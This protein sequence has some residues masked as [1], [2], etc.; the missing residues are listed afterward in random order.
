MQRSGAALQ[1]EPERDG[2]FSDVDF[3]TNYK[4]SAASWQAL[5][6]TI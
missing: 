1:E 2:D 6:N 5:R 3:Y 4:Y